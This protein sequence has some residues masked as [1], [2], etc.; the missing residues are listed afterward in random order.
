M[1]GRRTRSAKRSLTAIYE[2]T[3]NR[4][5]VC[6]GDCFDTPRFAVE[7]IRGWWACEGQ[8]RFPQAERLL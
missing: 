4:G 6:I 1:T 5:Y 7:A 3:T 8:R 2:L